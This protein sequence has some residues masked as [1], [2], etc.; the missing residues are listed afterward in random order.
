MGFQ[1]LLLKI[2]FPKRKVQLKRR[3]L[4]RKKNLIDRGSASGVKIPLPKTKPRFPVS[5]QQRKLLW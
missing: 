4:R 3:R 5:K 1:R 2:L